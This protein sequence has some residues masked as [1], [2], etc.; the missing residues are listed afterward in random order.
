MERET[1]RQTDQGEIKSPSRSALWTFLRVWLFGLLEALERGMTE[2]NDG[3]MK[4][5]RGPLGGRSD[6][7]DSPSI[8]LI[9]ENMGKSYYCGCKWGMEKINRL[10]QCECQRRN[11]SGLRGGKYLEREGLLTVA[12][13]LNIHHCHT[14]IIHTTAHAHSQFIVKRAERGCFVM[15][16]LAAKHFYYFFN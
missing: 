15:L 4:A 16:L 8:K 3:G 14:P 6:R 13:K 9:I 10:F 7:T 1:E 12:Y 11:H 2:R 5:E